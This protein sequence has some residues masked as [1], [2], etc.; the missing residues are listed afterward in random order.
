MD[1]KKDVLIKISYIEDNELLEEFLEDAKTIGLM[2][3]EVRQAKLP[4]RPDRISG[5]NTKDVMIT[6]SGDP[7]STEQVVAELLIRVED[8]LGLLP[9]SKNE[10]LLGESD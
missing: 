3:S 1:N 8:E 5:K 6:V 2:P 10:K 4:S 9:A 7:G